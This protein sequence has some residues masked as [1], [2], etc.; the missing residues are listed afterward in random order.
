MKFL[1]Y[2]L[3]CAF[4]VLTGCAS[5]PTPAPV[6]TAAELPE[7]HEAA[8]NVRTEVAPANVHE[9]EKTAEIREG[10]E[11]L[12]HL[13]NGQKNGVGAET[14]EKLAHDVIDRSPDGPEAVEALRALAGLK[15]ESAPG[16]ARLYIEAA[17][18]RAPEDPES[19]WL[20]GKIAHLQGLDNESIRYLDRAIAAQD[21]PIEAYVL[22][23]S[24]LLEYLDAALALETAQ[25][26]YKRYPDD[27]RVRTIVADARYASLDYAGAVAGY[28][29]L[30]GCV[31]TDAVLKNMAKIYEVHIQDAQKS[32]A[33]YELL[34]ERHPED[35]YY[36]AS[37]DYQCQAADAA[38]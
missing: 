33:I 13:R 37:R 29:N 23:T 4:A 21:A 28:E 5:S 24:I 38:D 14:L 10:S 27:C 30:D 9:P 16:H 35:A 2:S 15:A 3:W 22:K 17:L 12:R 18:E 32:C 25:Q 6:A 19:L 34:V 31:L 36:R 8:S 11:A 7:G 1:R 26:A 20:M